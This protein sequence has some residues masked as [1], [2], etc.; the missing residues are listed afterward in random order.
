MMIK[1]ESSE[2]SERE[3]EERE[4]KNRPNKQLLQVNKIFFAGLRIIV[5]TKIMSVPGPNI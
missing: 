5:T 1:I 4:N 3:R 2:K